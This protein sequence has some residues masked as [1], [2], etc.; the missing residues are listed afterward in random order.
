VLPNS[1]AVLLTR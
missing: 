1:I